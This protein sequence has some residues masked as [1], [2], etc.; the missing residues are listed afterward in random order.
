MNKKILS[1][2][3]TKRVPA[4]GIDAGL[5]EPIVKDIHFVCL[6]LSSLIFIMSLSF[7]YLP[8]PPP[9]PLFYILPVCHKSFYV[10]EFLKTLH[11]CTSQCEEL[12]IAMTFCWDT[13]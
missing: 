4:P 10:H 2:L 3:Q 13:F 5:G 7:L 9:P 6:V 12:H 11:A 1:K 8:P